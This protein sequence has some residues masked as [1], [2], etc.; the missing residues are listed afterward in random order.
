MVIKQSR[1]SWINPSVPAFTTILIVT[2][3]V[4]DKVAV[5]HDIGVEMID[6]RDYA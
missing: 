2:M 4:H 1:N 5:V 3:V 6:Y